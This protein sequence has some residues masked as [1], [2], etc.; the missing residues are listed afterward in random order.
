MGVHRRPRKKTTVADRV[1]PGACEMRQPLLV[2]RDEL[3]VEVD[4]VA[5]R[6]HIWLCA[7]L[8]SVS[9]LSGQRPASDLISPGSDLP[10]TRTQKLAPLVFTRAKVGAWHKP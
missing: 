4:A 1:E 2:R 8:I 6:G 9:V 5:A 3:H 10:R 7:S